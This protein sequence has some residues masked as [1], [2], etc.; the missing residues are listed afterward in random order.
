M[1]RKQTEKAIQLKT[2]AILRGKEIS[3]ERQQYKRR[4]QRAEPRV[5][6]N[7]DLGNYTQ[8]AKL[9]PNQ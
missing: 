3:S 9:V 6:E 7:S 8:E 4:I 1:D 5:K 2:R